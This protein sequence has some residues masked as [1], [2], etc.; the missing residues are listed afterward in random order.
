MSVIGERWSV[1]GRSALAFGAE[2]GDLTV[3]VDRNDGVRVDGGTVG[4]IVAIAGFAQCTAV[5]G[6]REEAHQVIAVA[7][8]DQHRGEGGIVHR[9]VGAAAHR[10]MN[11][12][13]GARRIFEGELPVTPRTENRN[14]RPTS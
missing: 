1:N 11:E 9:D 5:C 2:L 6:G 13:T 7:A 4:E 14:V 3:L 10:R 8:I 12:S